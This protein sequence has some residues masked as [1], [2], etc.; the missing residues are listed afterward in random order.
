MWL[1]WWLLLLLLLLGGK[2]EGAKAGK[3]ARLAEN[4]RSELE[5]VVSTAEHVLPVCRTAGSYM[6]CH[7][8][9]FR[10]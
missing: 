9:C 2:W 3:V 5:N 8:E 7:V 1:C 10:K 4:F 6:P